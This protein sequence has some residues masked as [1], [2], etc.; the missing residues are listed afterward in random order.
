MKQSFLILFLLPILGF[1]QVGS[2][3]LSSEPKANT[4][5]RIRSIDSLNAKDPEFK[6]LSGLEKEMY[7]WINYSR[8]YPKQFLDSALT[9]LL[10][11]FPNLQ[12]KNAESLKTAFNQNESLTPFVLN[13]RLLQ[14]AREQAKDNVAQGHINHNSLKGKPFYLRIR[15][16]GIRYCASEN[17]SNGP[18]DMLFQLCLLYLDIGVPGLGH[19]KALFNPQL[20]ELG[21][22]VA[23]QNA[24]TYYT[25]QDFACAQ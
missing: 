22:G 24:D 18:P 13:Y 19:R 6:H 21:L 9:P 3:S 11:Q 25:V 10:K 1:C 2:V 5:L 23:A 4:S 20:I 15:D 14:L 16:A 7:Y 8:I 12:G 17:I